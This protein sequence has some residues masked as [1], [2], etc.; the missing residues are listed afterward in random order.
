VLWCVYI[1]YLWRIVSVSCYGVV[2]WWDVRGN[3][4]SDVSNNRSQKA[5]YSSRRKHFCQ[6]PFLKQTILLATLAG[7]FSIAIKILNELPYVSEANCFIRQVKP[8]ILIH[9]WPK[10]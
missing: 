6:V 1:P 5:P 2:L 7:S 4:V 9:G 8:L 3:G 10:I